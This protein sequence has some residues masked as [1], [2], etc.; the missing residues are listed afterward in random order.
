MFRLFCIAALWSLWGNFSYAQIAA[1]Q[2]VPYRSAKNP[3]YWKNNPPHANYW[4][5]DVH[6]RIQATLNDSAETIAGSLQL[7]YHNNSPFPL[8]QAFFHLYQNATIQNSLAQKRYQTNKISTQLGR[9]ESQGLGTQIHQVRVNGIPIKAEI[10]HTLMQLDLPNV[11]QPG[12]SAIFNI[13]F[14]TYFDRGSIRRRMKVYDHHGLKH[15]N[16]VHWYPRI[17]VYDAKFSW[18]TDQHLEREF[19]G[20]FGSYDLAL[21]LP[22]HYIVEATGTLQNETEVLPDALRKKLDIRNFQNTPIGAIPSTPIPHSQKL[23][24]WK[25][26]ATNVHDIAWTADPSYRL[27]EVQQN[28]VRCI[29]IVQENN[30][31]KW[32]ETPQYIAKIIQFY[33]QLLG[34]YDYPKIVVADAADGME[35][36]ML[37][38]CGGY[39]PS[40]KNLI[41]HEV[42]HNWFQAMLGSNETYRS[43]LDEGFTQYINALALIY[44]RDE[45]NA[46]Y[47]RF[48]APYVHDAIDAEDAALNTHSNEFGNATGQGGGYHHVYVKTA[49]MLHALQYFLGDSLF[50]G[51]LKHYVKKWKF[52]HPYTEDFRQSVI[53]YA[54]TDLNK[55][56]DQWLESKDRIDYNIQKVRRNKDGSCDIQIQRKGNLIMPV[57]LVLIL[58]NTQN[59]QIKTLQLNIPS[60]QF[61][62][63]ESINLPVWH[64]WGNLNT[65]YSFNLPLDPNQEIE[66]IYLPLLTDVYQP[67]NVWKNRIHTSFDWGNPPSTA[68]LN[69]YT[70]RFRP[71]LRFNAANGF[72]LGIASDGQYADRRHVF[73]LSILHH[74][75]S[76]I[77]R[78]LPVQLPKQNLNAW[79][80]YHHDLIKGGRYFLDIISTQERILGVLGWNMK[81]GNHEFGIFGKHLQGIRMTSYERFN[82]ENPESK[83]QYDARFAGYIPERSFWN[84]QSNISMNLYWKIN[85]TAWGNRGNLR[86]DSRLASPWS[87]TQFGWIFAEW[88][89]YQ[90]LGKSQ[91]K[92][93]IF[94]QYGGGNTP[95][96]ESALYAAAANPETAFE[97]ALLRDIASINYGNLNLLQADP[98]ARNHNQFLHLAGGLNLRGYHGRSLGMQALNQDTILAFFRSPSGISTNIEWHWGKL[99]NGFARNAYLRLEP[100]IFADAGIAIIHHSSPKNLSGST[101]GNTNNPAYFSQI[102]SDAGIGT[103]IH[104]Q[105]LAKPF[106]RKILQQTR[107][108]VFRIDLPLFLSHTL[109]TESNFSFR[110][111]FGISTVF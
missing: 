64:S 21:S 75:G 59:K 100:Y 108:I 7:T 72:Q 90:N 35:Y 29:A 70:L 60:T 17:C 27:G 5:Q 25:F 28:G 96:P 95:A 109:E 76:P 13:E 46:E 47:N 97:N 98:F 24:T 51:A 56:F 11:L 41:A 14:T 62:H 89:H 20:E 30:A 84:P 8:T 63:P 50:F 3:H 36:P 110:F 49:S 66:Q 16:G 103:L 81:I 92:S 93:R 4:Q 86:I 52:T 6:Y 18:E 111:I 2:P 68:Y 40:H 26:H 58:K 43:L 48:L 42:G 69:P 102:L 31:A 10:D 105:N 19:Y 53:E 88:K 107:P 67:D 54:Q 65:T 83:H 9:Y 34:P 94:A 106:T 79:G 80:H 37:A 85:Y 12:D 22:E 82:S 78:N 39:Y 71:A 99:L 101:S 15:F 38:L 33:S 73:D 45:P 91:I 32:Q 57:R 55:F 1:S 61:Q 77:D 74:L 23:K 104:F 44:L 87:A